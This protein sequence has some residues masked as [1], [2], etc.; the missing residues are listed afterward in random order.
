MLLRVDL[1]GE[2]WIADVGFGG[3]T[4]TAPIRLDPD[5]T[6]ETPHGLFRLR[7]LGDAFLEEIRLPDGWTSLYRFDLSPA[8]P[9]DEE[10][11]NHFVSTWPTSHFRHRLT[12]ARPTA[13]GRAV[14]L[15]DR[16]TLYGPDGVAERRSLASASEAVSVLRERFGLVVPDPPAFAAAFDRAVATARGSP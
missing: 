2:A 11:A 14:L 4:L 16:L 8:A 9:I 15:N 5:R 7:R 6:Q 1:D 13:T 3:A 12:V 10:V